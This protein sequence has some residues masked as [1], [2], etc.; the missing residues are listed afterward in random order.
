MESEMQKE[1]MSSIETLSFED[2]Y[3]RLEEVI[4]R[5][6]QGDLSLEESV[7]LYEEGMS[8]AQHCGRQLDAAELRVTRLLSDTEEQEA[9]TAR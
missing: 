4:Q 6:E 5:L 1:G 2:S 8:L 3:A 9:A 7:A